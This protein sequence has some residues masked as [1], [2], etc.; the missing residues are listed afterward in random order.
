MNKKITNGMKSYIGCKK[1]EARLC[2][3]GYFLKLTNKVP[4]LHKKEYMDEIG[5]IVKYK[6]GYIS[7]SPK[8]VFERAYMEIDINPQI[9]REKI[10]KQVIKIL[11]GDN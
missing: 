8:D 2:T 6:D 9:T 11:I 7:W 10:D 4:Q 5:Y 1:V 3:R